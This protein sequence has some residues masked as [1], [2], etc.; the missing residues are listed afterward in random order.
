MLSLVLI[1]SSVLQA[2]ETNLQNSASQAK[3]QGDDASRTKA[4]PD[5]PEQ[6]LRTFL[7]AMAIKDAKA[8]QSVTLATKDFD[9]LLKGEVVPPDH[10]EEFKQIVAKIPIRSLKPGDE[11]TLPRNR[12]MKVRPD[13][14]GPDRAVLLPENAPIPNRVQKV[15]GRWRV[16]ATPIIAGRK[17]AEAARMKAKPSNR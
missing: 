2:Q 12:K 15:D 7:V 17:A 8:L 9:W 14:V 5:S 13:E 3:S 10:I 11:F 6:A 1:L 16:D 4:A